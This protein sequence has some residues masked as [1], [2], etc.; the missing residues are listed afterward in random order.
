MET[1]PSTQHPITN[2]PSPMHPPA[3]L[4]SA[5]SLRLL[6]P[7]LALA[8]PGAEPAR[9][10][11]RDITLL[12]SASHN[13]MTMQFLPNG[14][15]V[16]LDPESAM[17][18]PGPGSET[19][20]GAGAV[21]LYDGSTL[22]PLGILTGGAAG[23]H[24]G[25]GGIVPLPHGGFLILSPLWGN[26]PAKNAGAVTWCAGTG[27]LPAAISPDNSLVGGSAEDRVGYYPVKV[28]GN[29]NYVVPNPLWD[30][31]AAGNAGA[32]TFGNG[33]TGVRGLVSPLNS[34]VG[35]SPEDGVGGTLSMGDTVVLANGNY[36]VN[37]PAWDH[38]G[39]RDAGAVTWCSGATGRTG[40]VSA[41]NSLVGGT[42][43]DRVG[44]GLDS[45]G[46]IP[47]DH[48]NYVVISP[49]W[50]NGTVDDAGAVTW[51][52][53]AQGRT[54]PVSTANSLTGTA[55]QDRVG[56]S[57]W[58]RPAIVRLG[59]GNYLVRSPEW[60]RRRGAVT[61]CSGSS[62]I[63]GEVSAANSLVDTRPETT[64]TTG[65]GGGNYVVGSPYWHDSRGAVTWGSGTAGVSGE[66][67][68][69]NSLVGDSPADNVGDYGVVVLGNG[70]Y[71]VRSRTW[72]RGPGYF[73]QEGA[74]TWGS[75]TA[76]VTG[77]V[78]ELNSV[79]GSH[80][81]DGSTAFIVTAPPDGR[82]YL[83]VMPG[84]NEYR[85]AVTWGHGAAGTRGVVSPDISLVGSSPQDAVGNG[86]ITV[87]ANGHYVVNSTQWGNRAGAVTWGGAEK[88]VSGPVSSANSLTGR[89]S[90]NPFE[91]PYGSLV[92]P[93]ANG[94][95]VV[96]NPK[97][98][99]ESL[100]SVGAV[101]WCSGAEGRTGAV[102]AGNSLLGTRSQEGLGSGG[103]TALATGG[104]TVCTPWWGNAQGAVTWC[105][106]T[107]EITGTVSPEN[108][109]VGTDFYDLVGENGVTALPNGNYLVKSPN[110]QGARGAVTLG[111][112][113]QGTMGP[114]TLTNSLTG[115]QAADRVG[116]DVLGKPGITLLAN[117]NYVVQSPWWNGGRGAV[118]WGSGIAGMRGEVSM[119]NSL[120]GL[121]IPG[122]NAVR[123][124]TFSDGN[125]LVDGTTAPSFLKQ[126]IP[127]DGWSGTR[128][129]VTDA[130]SIVFPAG[131]DLQPGTWFTYDD[132]S[133]SRLLVGNTVTGRL[134]FFGTVPE[135][136]VRAGTWTGTGAGTAPVPHGQT[137]PET[138]N[139]TDFGEAAAERDSVERVFTILNTGM[140]PLHLTGTPLVT[141]EGPDAADFTVSVSALPASGTVAAAGGAAEFS[142]TF[143]PSAS[144][145]RKAVVR[146]PN[147]DRDE[148]DY[149]F[150]I[151][152]M[153]VEPDGGGDTVFAAWR[154]QYFG[155]AAAGTGHL[156]DFDSD[157][158]VN[159]LEFAF[160]THP[161]GGRSVDGGAGGGGVNSG[162]DALRYSGSLTEG[163]GT[164][165][166]TGQPVLARLEDGAFTALF[167]RRKDQAQAGLDYTPQFTPDPAAAAWTAITATPK[168]L[169][170][171]GVY[172]VVSVPFPFPAPAA[173]AAGFFRVRV[174]GGY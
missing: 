172:E 163:G 137:V 144:G 153:G 166:S 41:A 174:S 98:Y 82:Y 62:G 18:G 40:V 72:G 48:G 64:V 5:L 94:N 118:T 19:L 117:G 111:H 69:A 103:I 25:F 115:A 149:Q 108:S 97:W 70:N 125:Y 13:G 106:G 87:L 24:V 80:P 38:E 49:R 114:V 140:E 31:G 119:D 161:T 11:Q 7:L 170:E 59:N 173:V 79:V 57:E 132:K 91:W 85:G 56:G 159:L 167:I 21:Y 142:I 58:S 86:G 50:N 101:T 71:L 110:W 165:I 151:Q 52:S 77:E 145:L 17:P 3:R 8:F 148:S 93:L 136:A 35:S 26:G 100:E 29:G 113:A 65:V 133:G 116:A 160:G 102:S 81:G 162:P 122:S 53:G 20:E 60:G 15:I 105:G 63:T 168:V 124:V 12:P 6:F 156:G 61:W 10:G 47:L 134:S 88:G 78:S 126:L 128:G 66:I 45:N 14:N 68:A 155:N 96:C 46:V 74:V 32:V 157:G 92:T 42:E 83:V 2:T 67:T 141:L 73:T 112:G 55:F 76:G 158:V 1:A 127:G 51:C 123:I 90:P 43:D 30:H 54:G 139:G 95:Y 9:A 34:L 135:M 107:A 39:I 109:L 129:T 152:G 164:L 28:L 84:W 44:R 33:E 121:D 4:I 154:A 169:A 147:D 36:V 138:G 104:F 23:D 37:S 120:T 27:P 171:D 22:Q 150:A 130:V 16:V 89:P 99:N 146:I 75:G 143:K 131:T